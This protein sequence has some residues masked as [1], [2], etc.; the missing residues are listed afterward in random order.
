M[1]MT[2]DDDNDD[3]LTTKFFSQSSQGRSGAAAP[4]SEV[5]KEE[6]YHW[7][8]KICETGNVKEM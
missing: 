2:K 3:A 6:V 5:N 8:P 1:R 7:P 4:K